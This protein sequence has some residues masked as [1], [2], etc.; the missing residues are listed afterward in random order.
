MIYGDADPK[1]GET[2]RRPALVQASQFL[3]HRQRRADRI[4]R[5]VSHA[6]T[7]RVSPNRH[8][9]VPDE[10]VQRAAEAEHALD[11][12]SQ[13]FVELGDERLRVAFRGHRRVPADV[14]EQNR[15]RLN[16]AA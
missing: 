11:H 3:P 15:G 1:R 9:R 4:G 2:A 14:G 13:I 12:G 5:V 6:F 7:A 8:D 10:F 16:H